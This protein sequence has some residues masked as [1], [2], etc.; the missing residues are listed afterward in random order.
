MP[1]MNGVEDLP[2]HDTYKRIGRILLQEL[3]FSD[4]EIHEEHEIKVGGNSFRVDLVAIRSERPQ[5]FI[6][7]GNCSRDKIL[8]LHKVCPGL[9]LAFGGGFFLPRVLTLERQMADLERKQVRLRSEFNHLS[10]KVRF[11]SGQI[12]NLTSEVKKIDE[13]R[14][15]MAEALRD[16]AEAMKPQEYTT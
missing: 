15:R 2:R 3:G 1:R 6:E 13:T 4:D 14:R 16:A 7:V 10:E 5:F 8:Q 12:Y 11:E 9:N